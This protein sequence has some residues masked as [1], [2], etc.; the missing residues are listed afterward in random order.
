MN[1]RLG[2]KTK[3]KLKMKIII[4]YIMLKRLE[5]NLEMLKRNNWQMINWL[6]LKNINK[7]NNDIKMSFLTVKKS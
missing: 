7:N 6:S 1:I 5:N 4:I 2:K 3:I